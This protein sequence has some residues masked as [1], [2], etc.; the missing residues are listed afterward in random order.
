MEREWFRWEM[1]AGSTEA[2]LSA[3]LR[4]RLTA[5]AMVTIGK[6]AAAVASQGIEDI[7]VK[8]GTNMSRKNQAD[9]SL[10]F[11]AKTD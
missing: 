8:N 11:V 3:R 1:M 7:N 2:S 4:R 10:G 9:M 5:V 6:D